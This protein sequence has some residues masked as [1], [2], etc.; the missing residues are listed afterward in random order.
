MFAPF[1]L[2]TLLSGNRFNFSDDL[3]GEN[4]SHSAKTVENTI[5]ATSDNNFTD[6]RDQEAWKA[7]KKFVSS[8][9]L[10][11]AVGATGSLERNSRKTVRTFLR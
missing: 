10:R 7:C 1:T 11:G 4:L 2:Q 8:L 5:A 9:Y 3:R 6:K